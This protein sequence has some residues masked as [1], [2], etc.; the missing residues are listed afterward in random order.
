MGH[1]GTVVERPRKNGGIAYQA[2]VKVPGGKAAIGTF[3]TRELAQAFI[4]DILNSRKAAMA[5]RAAKRARP[6]T[7]EVIDEE[8][9]ELYDEEWLRTTLKLYS[10]SG[11]MAKRNY[12]A[13]PTILSFLGS[14][15]LNFV[16]DA[17][18]KELR[19][20]WV[21]DY[22]AFARKQTT[23]R[24]K[25]FAWSTIAG[26]L[27][28]IS[29]ALKWR[30]E[31]LEITRPRL[32]F[33][34]SMLPDGWEVRRDRRL[35]DGEENIIIARLRANPKKSKRHFLRLFRLSLETAA[36]LQELTLATWDEFNFEGKFWTIPSHHSKTKTTR[37]VPLTK[38]AMRTIKALKLIASPEDPRVFHTLKNAKGVSAVFGVMLKKSG[39]V[40]LR[41]HD[42]RHESVS[43]M[44][45]RQ[46]QFSIF[47]IMGIVGHSSLG[48][49]K[50]YANLRGD[51]L[52]AKLI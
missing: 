38:R 5:M 47:E 3:D 17:K 25:P 51:E 39:I 36:R 48:M 16:G 41:L 13:L 7:P 2:Q 30:A 32:P 50:R 31:E 42:L 19:R 37:V 4:D 12:S 35:K 23:A 1:K 21:K 24:G 11:D 8:N 34:T 14:E 29:V 15:K 33:S 18:L 49:L 28:L 52:S 44:V 26:H 9:Q 6:R 43:R 40:G 22:I 46:R 20:K 27:K 45:L 10:A